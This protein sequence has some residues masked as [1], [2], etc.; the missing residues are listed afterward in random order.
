M[1]VTLKA[2]SSRQRQAWLALLEVS[3]AFPSGWCV[4]GGQMVHLLCQE[5]GSTAN[6]PTNDGDVA[7]DIR[8]RPT[9]LRDFTEALSAQGFAPDGTSP[10]GHQHRWVRDQA[11]I[12]IL[13]PTSTGTRASRRTGVGGGTTLGSPGAQQ[14]LR[15]A[16]VVSVRVEGTSGDVR[17]PNLLGALVSKA[18]AFQVPG[19]R[20]RERH[21]HDFATLAALIE[22]S[23]RVHQQLTGRDRFYLE[24]MLRSLAGSRGAWLAI[25]GAERGVELLG[26]MMTTAATATPDPPRP[27]PEL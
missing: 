1:T 18:A 27:T 11:S 26:S 21:L 10:E 23:D 9:I 12:D 25:E 24:P 14:A 15:R 13:I 19:D 8:A 4:V 2:L 7:L 6:R 3:V 17:R 20:G 5:R 16:E 22:R